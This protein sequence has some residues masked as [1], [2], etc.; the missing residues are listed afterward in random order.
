MDRELA[1]GMYLLSIHLQNGNKTFHFVM[2][3]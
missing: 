3:Q 1:N 2:E